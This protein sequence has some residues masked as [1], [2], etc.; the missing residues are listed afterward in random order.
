MDEAAEVLLGTRIGARPVGSDVPA[1][2]SGFRRFVSNIAAISSD[3]NLFTLVLDQP[4]F[5]A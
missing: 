4:I 3:R 2:E 5:V 1:A